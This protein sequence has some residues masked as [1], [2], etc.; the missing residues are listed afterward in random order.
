MDILKCIVQKVNFEQ[1]D[2]AVTLDK[3][4]VV[5]DVN[6]KL[7]NLVEDILDSYQKDGNPAY[8]IY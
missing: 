2:A 6:Q 5:L 8:A 7:E 3:R 1:G 4:P